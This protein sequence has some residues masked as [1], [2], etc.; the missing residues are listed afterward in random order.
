MHELSEKHKAEF[1]KQVKNINTKD[2]S[3]VKDKIQKEIDELKAKKNTKLSSLIEKAELFSN[4]L[5]CDEFPISETSRKWIIFGL[6]YLVSD[7]DLIPD[8]IPVIG[9]TDDNLILSWVT[10]LISKD[11]E[12]YNHYLKAKNNSSTLLNEV[13][14]GSGEQQFLFFPGFFETKDK[15]HNN[16]DWVK[17]IRSIKSVYDS[18]GISILDWKFDFL[19]EFRNTLPMIDHKLSLKP[20]FDSEA[21]DLEWK[22]LKIEMSILGKKIEDEL[23]NNKLQY[24]DKEVIAICLNVGSSP[25]VEAQYLS[26]SKLVD[27][28]YLFGATCTEQKLVDSIAEKGIKVYNFYS[29]NDHA[30]KFIYDNYEQQNIPTGLGELHSL[31]TT[32]I[33]NIDISDS[34]NKHQEYRYNFAELINKAK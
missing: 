27:E 29:D 17:L 21:F 33:I 9:Y 13:V 19:K 25:L 26:D 31:K 15:N 3:K 32:G 5:K 20:I 2:E 8:A 18:P 30:L 6:N 22:Q 23:S 11:I 12:R 16:L 28:I 4:I 34:I 24:P 14:Q 1:L 10:S 7:V